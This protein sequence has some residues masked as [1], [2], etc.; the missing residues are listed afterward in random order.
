MHA[1]LLLLHLLPTHLVCRCETAGLRSKALVLSANSLGDYA[2]A[3]A[4]AH[5]RITGAAQCL[6]QVYDMRG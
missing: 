1:K 6:L 3:E 4:Q 5:L 2:Q